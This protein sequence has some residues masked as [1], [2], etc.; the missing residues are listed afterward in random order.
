MQ[1]AKALTARHYLQAQKIRTHAIKQV[2]AA[3]EVNDCGGAHPPYSSPTH[4]LRC[5]VGSGRDHH[6]GDSMHTAAVSQ[7][8]GAAREQ[9]WE[10]VARY[11]VRWKQLRSLH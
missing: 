5:S 9:R 4:V 6:S 2:E 7:R 10:D 1:L 8:D 3:F 11:A